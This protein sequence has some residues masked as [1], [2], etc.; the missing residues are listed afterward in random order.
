M[1]WLT[2]LTES[3]PCSLRTP[4]WWWG[5]HVRR[6]RYLTERPG[7]AGTAGSSN[8]VKFSKHKCRVLALGWHNQRPSLWGMT[9]G[10]LFWLKVSSPWRGEGSGAISSQYSS[11][12][13]RVNTKRTLS[14]HEEPPGEDKGQF[15]PEKISSLY[16]KTVF[17]VRIV[18][19]WNNLRGWVIVESTSPEDFYMW[20]V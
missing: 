13:S 20:L 14:L 19:H 10:N 11:K 2:R 3:S 1:T 15:R 12:Y 4:S 6:E 17:T 5:G 9:E 7:Q 18:I 16:N 8:C